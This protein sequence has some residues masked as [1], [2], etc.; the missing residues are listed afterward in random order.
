MEINITNNLSFT[1]RIR[2][3]WILR[4][5]YWNFKSTFTGSYRNSR[6]LYWIKFWPSLHQQA[7]TKQDGYIIRVK[8]KE[9]IFLLVIPNKIY[10]WYDVW[11]H[12]FAIMYYTHNKDPDMFYSMFTILLLLLPIRIFFLLVVLL[13]CQRYFLL[14]NFKYISFHAA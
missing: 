1:E 12:Q 4:V 13:T 14:Q 7:Y 10:E 6:Y 3:F 8:L 5:K 2:S 11:G 9:H